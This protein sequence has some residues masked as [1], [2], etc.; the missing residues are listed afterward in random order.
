[1]KFL[2]ELKEDYFL[3]Y[4]VRTLRDDYFDQNNFVR[5]KLSLNWQVEQGRQKYN[6]PA[7]QAGV[8]LAN[9]V[10]WQQ[11]GAY[12]PFS[13][14]DIR[15]Q[16]LNDA[17]VARDVTVKTLIPLIFA[18]EAWAKVNFDTFLN[19]FKDNPTFL[20][21]GYFNYIVGRGVSL[22]YHDDMAVDYLGWPGEN[23]Y[24]KYSNMPP[25]ILLK[26]Y[27]KDNLSLDLYFMK[28]RAVGASL[29]D[30]LNPTRA[31]RLDTG[32]VERGC[33]KDT[34]NYVLKLDYTPKNTKFGDVCLE[35]YYIYTRAPEQTVELIGDSAS[36]LHTIGAMGDFNYNNFNVNIECAG[37][38]GYQ[39]LFPIDRNEILLDSS[40]TPVFS[41]IVFENPRTSS[42]SG[43]QKVPTF[44]NITGAEHP[45]G[46]YSPSNDLKY[47]V[48]LPINRAIEKSVIKDNTGAVLKISKQ[49]AKDVNGYKILNSDDFGNA[50]FRNGYKLNF[51]GLMLLADVSYNF[52]K[53]PFKA[54]GSVGYISGDAYPYNEERT[55]NFGAFIPLRS[56]YRGHAVKNTLIFDRLDL[57]RP[58]NISYK[59]MYAYNCLNDLSNLQ[60][61]GF[62]TTWYPLSLRK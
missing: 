23:N 26:S 22:G 11:H 21:V 30:T 39:E 33:N 7:T 57:P 19:F 1:M 8:K 25:G 54:G 45:E 15:A 46:Y 9:Y 18:E 41:H 48:N 13:K 58:L 51:Q 2:G 12:L 53:H 40:G 62:S 6:K 3:Y 59:N 34:E 28:W 4:G 35:P 49:G 16:D 43:Y 5:H 47:I 44:G 61:F 20:Q 42:R 29:S 14:V 52:P 32:G 37:Q 50:R 55:R 10:Y 36:Y 31:Q 56:Q 17:I 24:Q 38:V 60:F 27:I